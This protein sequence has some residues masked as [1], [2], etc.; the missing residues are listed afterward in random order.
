ME[1]QRTDKLIRKLVENRLTRR[2][3]EEIISGIEDPDMAKLFE[4]S[5]KDH[6]EEN[7]ERFHKKMPIQ[8]GEPN[9][10]DGG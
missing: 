2:E 7:L 3:F 5:L 9:N 8:K 4:S 6:F 1:K 10:M